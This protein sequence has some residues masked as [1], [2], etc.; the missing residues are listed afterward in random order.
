MDPLNQN[1]TRYRL[2]DLR[3]FAA[4][5]GAAAGLAPARAAA[6]AS[7]L[8]WYDA[9]GLPGAGL[10]TLPDWLKRLDDQEIDPKAEGRVGPEHTATAVFDGQ[11][12]VGPLILARAAGIAS[13]KAREIGVGL[14]RV[15]GLGPTGPA[16]AVVAE[17][18]IGPLAALAIGPGGARAVAYPS[19]NGLPAV[20]DSTLAPKTTSETA[21]IDQLLIPEGDWLIQVVSIG[22]IEPLASL[23]E[24]IT[25]ALGTI[26][27]PPASPAGLLHPNT[28]EAHRRQARER[29]VP[30][31]AKLI[32]S[33]RRWALKLGIGI[34]ATLE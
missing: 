7:M 13:E 23:Q 15:R 14:V 28:W 29:G 18:A 12:G 1:P 9:A 31:D 19:A 26:A 27:S 17:V 24:R 6:L 10:A 34:P 30:L 33:L 11:N 2:D 3:H 5:L 20:F 22:A 25:S 16:A 21:R 4:A 8:L 32:K